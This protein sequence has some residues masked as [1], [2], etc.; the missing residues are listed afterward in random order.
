MHL[1]R[2]LWVTRPSQAVRLGWQ[3]DPPPSLAWAGGVRGAARARG[4][5]RW[6][7]DIL[8]EGAPLNFFPQKNRPDTEKVLKCG[9]R[10][11]IMGLMEGLMGGGWGDLDPELRLLVDA[12][13]CGYDRLWVA[14]ARLEKEVLELRER[15]KQ[16]PATAREIECF[17]TF[18]GADPMGA[19]A[20]DRLRKSM[21]GA[22]EVVIGID[23]AL[24]PDEG[25]VE[26]VAVP[27]LG[28][29]SVGFVNNHFALAREH[30][31][32][33][34]LE[35]LPGLSP[36][37]FVLAAH[38]LLTLVFIPFVMASASEG[39]ARVI[40]AAQRDVDEMIL[41]NNAGDQNVP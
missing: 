41:A 12:A 30:L 25:M 27:A 39:L 17:E 33:G 16:S 2:Q 9:G 38:K 13:I 3:A 14:M 24:G 36:D 21:M 1:M 7:A 10:I 22:G 4:R 37:E 35:E 32:R 18:G 5:E 26:D 40:P 28:R 19:L 20:I 23:T 34:I 15:L 31:R 11:R 29:G 6:D 8:R